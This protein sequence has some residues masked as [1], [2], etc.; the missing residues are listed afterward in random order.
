MARSAKK[1]ETKTTDFNPFKVKKNSS[2]KS[3]LASHQAK[4]TIAEAVDEYH[5]VQSEIKLLEGQQETCKN[6]VLAEARSVFA[7]RQING[8]QGNLKILGKEESVTFITQNSGSQLSEEDLNLIEEKFGKKTLNALTEP[9]LASL[10]FNPSFI[11]NETTQKRLFDALAKTFSKDEL[12]NM[13]QPI[14]HKVKADTVTEAVKYVK[15]ADQLADLYT[16]LKLKS[17]IKI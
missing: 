12:E 11:G 1:T 9:D 14:A 13:F 2:S 10:K 7:E 15:S 16:A 8:E 5:R 4:G 17:Y 6:T 3:S